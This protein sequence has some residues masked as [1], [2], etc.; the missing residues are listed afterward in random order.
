MNR[1]LFASLL[2]AAACSRGGT[3]G[4]NRPDAFVLGPTI[5]AMPGG[6]QPDARTGGQ[7]P[8][9]MPVVGGADAA[10]GGC[11]AASTYPDS[12]S[13]PQAV[14]FFN[15]TTFNSDLFAGALTTTTN[16]DVAQFELYKGF[17]VFATDITV[18]TYT[19]SGVETQ[20]QSCGACL[21]IRAGVT[22]DPTTHQITA[23]QATYLATGGTLQ[24][25]AVP[26][27]TDGTGTL[28]GKLTNGTFQQVTIDS[29]GKS[30]PVGTCTTTIPSLTF[31]ATSTKYTCDANGMNCAP[32]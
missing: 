21:L 27:E 13:S 5:D 15:T 16:P 31:S 24:L 20:Y 2:A 10:P 6:Q 29:T 1:Y 7:Q 9:A 22:I 11:V 26:S 17:G 32:G 3:P 19:I 23:E 18:N 8:D 28:S 30:T 14:A 25:T 12:V 4:G